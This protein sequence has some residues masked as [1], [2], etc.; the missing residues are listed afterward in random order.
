M[1]FAAS[2]AAPTTT[3]GAGCKSAIDLACLARLAGDPFVR[4]VDVFIV[5]H[6]LVIGVGLHA[7]VLLILLARRQRRVTVS[8][9]GAVGASLVTT[10]CDTVS[11]VYLRFKNPLLFELFQG[12]GVVFVG[13]SVSLLMYAFI[14]PLLHQ[15][16]SFEPF[17][18]LLYVIP[19]PPLVDAA[20]IVWLGLLEQRAA[21]ETDPAKLDEIEQQHGIAS[22]LDGAAGSAFCLVFIIFI[23][24]AYRAFTLELRTTLGPT[25]LARNRMRSAAA[26]AVDPWAIPDDLRAPTEPSLQRTPSLQDAGDATSAFVGWNSDGPLLSPAYSLAPD[27]KYTVNG[28]LQ[29]ILHMHPELADQQS[30]LHNVNPH[31]K[32]QQLD[33]QQ[34]QLQQH[35][36]LLFSPDAQPPFAAGFYPPATPPSA[37][38]PSTAYPPQP[39]APPP[40]QQQQHQYQQQYKQQ[41][42]SRSHGQSSASAAAAVQDPLESVEREIRV[43]AVRAVRN[44][45]GWIIVCLSISAVGLIA[46]KGAGSLLPGGTTG[47]AV[48][49]AGNLLQFFCIGA[50]VVAV[51]IGQY[52]RY[53]LETVK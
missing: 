42:S 40:P 5:L 12:A 24:A 45:V 7:L 27:G 48:W 53:A 36:Q 11:L 28:G 34:L 33:M 44:L 16:R 46:T 15:V 49:V 17:M 26:A 37:L 52:R 19:I 30:Q 38:L 9:S 29:V 47:F 20:A 4:V 3:D 6:V 25:L 8:M 14:H 13:F 22:W 50:G 23:V 32:Q 2:A 10:L 21:D 43:G 1:T 31:F 39:S 35:Q 51:F 41:A 18:R